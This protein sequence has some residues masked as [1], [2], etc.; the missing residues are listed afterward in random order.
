MKL[1]DKKTS[2][3]QSHLITVKYKQTFPKR[4]P[5]EKRILRYFM[6]KYQVIYPCHIFRVAL[7]E[8]TQKVHVD[9]SSHF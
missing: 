1:F 2:K 3:N 6:A 9:K 5:K 4:R 8:H 7:H